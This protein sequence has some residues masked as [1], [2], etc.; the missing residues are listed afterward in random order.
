MTLIRITVACPEALIADANHLAMV[1]A[2]G[3]EDGET[4]GQPG[5]QDAEG[6]L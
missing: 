4:Y 6:N 5:W 3:P 2:Q 1:L